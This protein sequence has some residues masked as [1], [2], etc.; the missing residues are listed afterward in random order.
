MIEVIRFYESMCDKAA[1]IGL[2]DHSVRLC[3][4]FDV[5]SRR[6]WP[7]LVPSD[8]D[9]FHCKLNAQGSQLK[10]ETATLHLL[11]ITDGGILH[12]ARGAPL[13][14]EQHVVKVAVYEPSRS[15]RQV[16]PLRKLC[17]N[18]H[19]TVESLKHRLWSLSGTPWQTLCDVASPAR[20]RLRSKRGMVV[21]KV[22]SDADALGKALAPLQDGTELAVQLLAWTER[23]QAGSILVTVYLWHPASGQAGDPPASVP[24][25]LDI[26]VPRRA[27]VEELCSHISTCL[28]EQA[29]TDCST[30]TMQQMS[31]TVSSSLG[32][33]WEFCKV[34]G[35]ASRLAGSSLTELRFSSPSPTD[36]ITAPPLGLRDQS[37]VVVRL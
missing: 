27:T 21:S 17:V 34:V 11:G 20:L 33:P 29:S 26:L 35:P 9:S 19:D 28:A 23:S 25:S 7:G 4:S 18:E 14:P 10:D 30:E 32:G 24:V 31:T 12:L 13:R 5:N 8:V 37:R 2:M 16:R 15:G 6:T 22:L 36:A 1:S 3:W